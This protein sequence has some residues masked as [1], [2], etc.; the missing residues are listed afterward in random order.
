MDTTAVAVPYGQMFVESAGAI[1]SVLVAVAMAGLGFALHRYFPQFE[2][3]AKTARV[4]QL[5][6]QAISFAIS[7]TANAE[8]GKTWTVDTGYAV[9]NT[10]LSR[11]IETRQSW[12]SSFYGD[13]AAAA[14]GLWGRLAQYLPADAVAPDFHAV[15]LDVTDKITPTAK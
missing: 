1:A 14:K 13:E 8:A 3:L 4:D 7:S 6:T 5:M 2:G 11:V 9:L 15:A 12:F 10:A